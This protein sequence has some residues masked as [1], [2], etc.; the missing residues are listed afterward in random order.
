M[1]HIRRRLLR[2]LLDLAIS[3]AFQMPADASRDTLCQLEL[4]EDRQGISE[5]R[6]IGSG[7]AAG[8]HVERIADDVG[9]DEAVKRLTVKCLRESPPLDTRQMLADSVHLID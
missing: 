5:C 3:A 1:M 9:D 4:V 6:R 8:D 7:G 2:R